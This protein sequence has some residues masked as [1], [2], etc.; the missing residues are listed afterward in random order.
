[1]PNGYNGAGWFWKPV[2][3]LCISALLTGAGFVVFMTGVHG[4]FVTRAEAR[5]MVNNAPFPWN[6]DRKYVLESLTE[7]KEDTKYIKSV[8]WK[9]TQ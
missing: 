5:E 7:I 9:H 8:M 3:L 4:T 2:A 6:A 1:M